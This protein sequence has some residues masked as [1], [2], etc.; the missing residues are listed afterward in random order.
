MEIKVERKGLDIEYHL[1]SIIEEMLKNGT[2]HFID[3][4]CYNIT[5]EN[6]GEVVKGTITAKI[7]IEIVNAPDTLLEKAKE[8]GEV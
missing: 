7:S 4:R 5:I 3:Q 8:E 6:G 1:E 2:T